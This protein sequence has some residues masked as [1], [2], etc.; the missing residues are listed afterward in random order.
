MVG[1]GQLQAQPATTPSTLPPDAI[2]SRVI[3]ISD[4]SGVLT[5]HC[6]AGKVCPKETEGIP[7]PVNHDQ[8]VGER[9]GSRLVLG[10]TAGA[11]RLRVPHV[12]HLSESARRHLPSNST[13]IMA[14][15]EKKK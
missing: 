7:E 13:E 11:P 9:K 12:Y 3:S 2:T 6:S 10:H 14:I 4:L 1:P 8:C 5:A 15:I